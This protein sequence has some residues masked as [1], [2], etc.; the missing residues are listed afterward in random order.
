MAR[1]RLHITIT[2]EAGGRVIS[3]RVGRGWLIF[4]SLFTT[5]LLLGLG[6]LIFYQ[7]QDVVKLARY[8]FMRQQNRDLQDKMAKVSD[9]ERKLR[10]AED[11]TNR[12]KDALLVG[13]GEKAAVDKSPASALPVGRPELAQGAGSASELASFVAN[14]RGLAT[15]APYL[16]PVDKG[17]LVRGFGRIVSPTGTEQFH[18]GFDIACDNGIPVHAT[19]AGTVIWV[20]DD[21]EYGKLIVLDHGSTGFS[22]FYGHLSSADVK[23]GQQVTANMEIGKTGSSGASSD[24]HL[25]YEV[26]WDNLPINPTKYLPLGIYS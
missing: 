9:L 6:F 14:S 15:L 5:F 11:R 8:E 10:A 24:Y 26:R 18:T 23:V 12:I 16:S 21:K 2:P 3:L 20:G 19:A 1:R 13:S 22:T 4:L 17:H 25:H 7:A